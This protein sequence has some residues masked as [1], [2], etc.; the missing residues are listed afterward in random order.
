MKKAGFI[1]LFIIFS[2]LGSYTEICDLDSVIGMAFDKT[3]DGWQ[4]RCEIFVP[5]SDSDFGNG[6]T[7]REGRGATLSEALSDLSAK[8]AKQLWYGSIQ[9]Y[10][11]GSGAVC[12]PSLREHLLGGGVN[13]RA[14]TVTSD[15]ACAV[16]KD[17]REHSLS[18]ARKAKRVAKERGMPLPR[19]TEYLRG[20]KMLRLSEGGL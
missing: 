5:S 2:A 14:V 13:H 18:L 16:L 4:V 12:D 6:C 3:P 8:S 7:V 19:V 15:S 17:G 11:I 9:L 1:I 10:I 20:G